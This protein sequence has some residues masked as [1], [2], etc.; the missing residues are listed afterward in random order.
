MTDTITIH[1]IGQPPIEVD[2]SQCI[3]T[4]RTR[5]EDGSCPRR[6]YLR[7]ELGGFGYISPSSN[8]DLVIGGA[9]HEGLDLLLQGGTLKKALDVADEY[10]AEHINYPDYLLPEQANALTYDGAH[11]VSAFIYAF[12]STYLPQLLDEYEVLDV[13]DEVNWLVGQPDN[14]T[15]IIMMSRPDGVLRHKQTG[16]LWHVSHKTS[17]EFSTTQIEKLQID[18]QR[19]SESMA[20]WAKYGEAPEGT[21]YNYFIKGRRYEDKDLGISRFNSGLIHPYIQRISPGGELNPEMISFCYEWQELDGHILRNRRLG[22]GWERVSIY[23]EMDFDQYLNW[24]ELREVPRGRDYLKESIV[25]LVQ[26]PFD[27]RFA[28]RWRQGIEFS[29]ADWIQ[30]VYL[31]NDDIVGDTFDSHIPLNSSE[32]FAWNRRCPYHSI[33]WK[34]QP[35]ESLITDGSLIPR[36]P[37]HLVEFHKITKET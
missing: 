37:N 30:R 4:D 3:F 34:R 31:V 12:N 21:L 28:E 7:Y 22:K 20:I 29:E 6:R 17:Q 24:L 25:G 5:I 9:T 13:E 35:I 23:N 8:E 15:Y 16:R 1:R 19:F 26:E 10:F 27:Q 11:L 32:C 2:P 18:I 33:C 14:D 36:E